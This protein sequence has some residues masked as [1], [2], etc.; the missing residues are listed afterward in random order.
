M[1]M[2]KKGAS[3]AP[4][5][6]HRALRIGLLG[7]SRIAPISLIGPAKGERNITIVCVASRVADRAR[8][9]AARHGVPTSA[10]TY[11]A[12][13]A[14]NDIDL[15]H[16]GLPVS[17]HARWTIEALKAGKAVLC[18]KPL[19][20]NATEARQ[21]VEIARQAGRPLIEAYHYLFHPLIQRVL[22]IVRS[23]ELGA[24]RQAKAQFRAML[25]ASDWETRWRPELGGGALLDLGCYPVHILRQVFGAEPVVASSRAQMQHGVDAEIAADLC[26]PHGATAEINASMVSQEFSAGLWL[27]G[28]RGNL[29][30]TNFVLPHLGSEFSVETAQGQR[31]ESVD[32]TSTFVWQLRHVGEVMLRRR[33]PM[34]GGEDAI[35]TMVVLDT[36]RRTAGL[37]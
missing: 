31:S 25:P 19:S 32:G 16:I 9:F 13:L 30:V 8:A 3:D 11:E 24:I 27:S 5:M 20:R 15:V 26:F 10:A 28:E 6:L 14:R 37:N 7:A 36:I 17:E 12:L 34:T 35:R 2:E 18:E 1:G 23:R 4:T 33:L 29:A 22:S 21:M